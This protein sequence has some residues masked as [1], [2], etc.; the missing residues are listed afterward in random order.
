MSDTENT[1]T[2]QSKKSKGFLKWKYLISIPI[3]TV[4]ILIS[5][6]I[7]KIN[8]AKESCKADYTNKSDSYRDICPLS[9]DI[10]VPMCSPNNM[11]CAFDC[12]SK[13]GRCYS[14]CLF[15]KFRCEGSC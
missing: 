6:I 10:C 9:K 5:V 8:K 2:E 3:I 4:I 15:D 1:S 7:V 12:G 13:W 11:T 14:D